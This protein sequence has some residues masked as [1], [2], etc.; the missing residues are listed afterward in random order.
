MTNPSISTTD[1]SPMDIYQVLESLDIAYERLDHEAAFTVEQAD[2]IYG[3]LQGGFTKNLFLRNKK[4]NRHYLVVVESHKQVDLK[5]M[6][7]QI[8]E[9]TLSFASEDRLM[10]YLGLKPGSVSPLGL[11]NDGAGEVA[12]Y[13]DQ[14]LLRHDLLNFH[15]DQNT[16][17]LTLKTSDLK[18]FV[19]HTGHGFQ[20]MEIP[21]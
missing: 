11:I 3:H 4:G 13:F 19:G 12:V 6:R 17:T 5:S 18:K 21:T 20:L 7:A 10:R 15:P 8:G 1:L 2:R 16:T 14:D 9:S